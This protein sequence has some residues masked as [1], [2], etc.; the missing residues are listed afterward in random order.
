[1]WLR[2]LQVA[3]NTCE[4]GKELRP[5][6]LRQTHSQ[7]ASSPEKNAARALWITVHVDPHT[8]TLHGTLAAGMK[9]YA[10]VCCVSC[11]RRR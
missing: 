2:Q 8:A 7:M 5:R 1:M 10:A 9:I 6:A 11:F 4:D 3:S